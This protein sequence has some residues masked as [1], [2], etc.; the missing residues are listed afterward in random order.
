M[1]DINFRAQKQ[2]T[3][4]VFDSSR[5]Y[6]APCT[7]ATAASVGYDLCVSADTIVPPG[8]IERLPTNIAMKIPLECTGYLLPRSSTLRKGLDVQIGVIDPDYRGEIMIQVRNITHAPILVRAGDK[9]A[10]LTLNR[11][12]V[13]P[14]CKAEL[15]ETT[16]GN[17]G[18]GSTDVQLPKNDTD[19]SV[20]L[21]SGEK[22]TCVARDYVSAVKE[23]CD[24]NKVD[25]EYVFVSK[26]KRYYCE[27]IFD[28]LRFT[29]KEPSLSK[30][31][32][33]QYCA[34]EIFEHIRLLKNCQ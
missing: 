18:F 20:S 12:Y 17:G 21:I 11:V 22:D 5:P 31:N 8:A 6:H 2:L 13:W 33:K 32:S 27:A 28:G 7:P 23:W 15:D 25:C 30:A 29:T 1:S 26:N 24:E 4:N 16:R 10:Q 19:V 34:K 9:I 3:W 14:L